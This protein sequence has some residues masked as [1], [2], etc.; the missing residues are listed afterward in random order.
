MPD[1]ARILRL[2]RKAHRL[3]Q[4]EA[5]E[6]FVLSLPTLQRVEA[7][8][9]GLSYSE[10]ERI[11]AFCKTNV[12]EIVGIDVESAEHDIRPRLFNNTDENTRLEQIIATQNEQ[13]ASLV[14]EIR[15]LCGAIKEILGG[16]GGN[17]KLALNIL[18]NKPYAVLSYSRRRLRQRSAARGF[19]HAELDAGRVER[20][21]GAGAVLFARQV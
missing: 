17:N 3:T 1:F 9:R 15:G 5:A 4:E 12:H 19:R 20:T 21:P 13:I 11:A 10:L 14:E 18:E 6:A 16:G 2:V 7:G 8:K